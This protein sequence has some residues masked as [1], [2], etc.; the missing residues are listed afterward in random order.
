MKTNPN[1]QHDPLNFEVI[2]QFPPPCTIPHI[3]SLQGKVNFLRCFLVNYAE[4]T[5][6]FMFL[7]KKGVPLFWDEVA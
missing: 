1:N 7:L 6:G 3:Q 2:V 4:I 5:K